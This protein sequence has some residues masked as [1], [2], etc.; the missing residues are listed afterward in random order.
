MTKQPNRLAKESSPYL[1]QHAYNP[2]DWFPWNDEALE[3]ARSENKM[4]IVSIGYSACHWCHVMEHQSFEDEKVAQIMNDLF[5]CIKVDREERPDIDQVYMSAVQIMTG[6][7]GWPLN[8]FTLPDGRPI[9]GG[10]YFPKERW[11]T[12]LL[13][14]ADLW[15]N[16]PEKCMQYAH[17]LTQGVQQLDSK[18]WSYDGTELLQQLP[19]RAWQGW[20]ERIDT[21]EGGPN[22]APKFPLPNNYLFLLRYHHFSGNEGALRHVTLTLDKIAMGGINDHVG[23]GFARYSTDMLWKVPHFEK[24]LYDNGQLVSLYSEAYELTKNEFYL[25]TVR[26]TLRWVEREMTSEEGAFYSALDADSE[27]EEGKFYVWKKEELQHLLREE[28]ELMADVF[29]VN[30]IGY[31]EEENYVLIMRESHEVLAKRHGL[32]VAQLKERIAKA[33]MLLLSE[34]SKRVR[35]G[36]D[37]KILTSWNA[38]MLRGYVDAWKVTEDAEY[39]RAAKRNAKFISEKQIKPDGTLW[40]SYKNGTSTINGFLEDYAFVIDAFIALY[41]TDFREEYQLQ[42]RALCETALEKFKAE[43]SPMLYFTSVDDQKLITRKFETS[44]NVIPASNSVMAR[45]LFYLG[46]YF[47]NEAWLQQSAEMLK[48]VEREMMEYAPGYSNWLILALHKL[49]PSKE[50]AIVGKAVDNTAAEFRKLYLPNA[51]FAG[52]T[53]QSAVPVLR[54][55]FKEGKTVI[56]VCENNSC[57]LPVEDVAEAKKQ[58]E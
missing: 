36:L 51:I 7:G 42:A 27:G 34:R 58:L 57:R 52:S 6:Q 2:V 41:Q 9:Y 16:E 47:G 25:D 50:V 40:H 10:T 53:G 55:R 28:Y 5:V 29:S 26:D 33:K 44:D 37:D 54:D 20:S 31:W 24:M 46:K 1:L 21:T 49:Y 45:N 18:V 11:I 17:E 3:K 35:P 38:I 43:D 14:L 19:D 32:S 30:S 8:C 13:N 23:G 12:T 22:R 48:C 39:L 56:Y 4:I 15:K